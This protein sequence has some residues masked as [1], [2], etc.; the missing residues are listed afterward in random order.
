MLEKIKYLEQEKSDRT[1]WI[2]PIASINLQRLKK[3]FEIEKKCGIVLDMRVRKG[4]TYPGKNQQNLFG[5]VEFAD[6]TSVARALHLAAKKET[7]IDGIK[8]RIYKA[9][10]GTFLFSKKSSK[11]K[12]LEQAQQSLPPVPYAIQ[13]ALKSRGPRGMMTRGVR[14]RGRGG[15]RRNIVL[16]KQGPVTAQM[17]RR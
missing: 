9:G 13:M 3:F 5:F 15:M 1:V 6:E 4:R 11:Q 12:K 14:G 10:T 17:A 2:H 7:V 8:F 16:S